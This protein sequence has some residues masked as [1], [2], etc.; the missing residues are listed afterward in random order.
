MREYSA[1]WQV[2]E[3]N[4]VL[5]FLTTFRRQAFVYLLLKYRIGY[6]RDMDVVAY[7]N[8]S[9]LDLYEGV[10]Y[11]TKACQPSTLLD[12][13]IA[14]ARVLR[15]KSRSGEHQISTSPR[16]LRGILRRRPCRLRRLSTSSIY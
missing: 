10:Y 6:G 5:G 2:K 8:S 11:V 13:E 12:S 14:R 1:L 4:A 15:I 16:D 3:I 7:A 9:S